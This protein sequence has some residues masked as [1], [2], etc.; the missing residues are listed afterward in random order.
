MR[1]LGRAAALT[2]LGTALSV[3]LSPASALGAATT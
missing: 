2:V 3:G 1:K